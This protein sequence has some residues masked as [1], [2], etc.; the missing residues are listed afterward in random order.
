MD[1]AST[2]EYTV[3]SLGA[4]SLLMLFQLIV[5]DVVGIKSK[6][7]PGSQIPSDHDNL[8]FRSS[9][10]VT[11]IGESVGIFFLAVMYCML[12]NASPALTAYA[13]WAFVIARSFYTLF[14][15]ANLKILRSLSFGCSLLALLALI[16]I[17]FKG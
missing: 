16:V 13:A 4:L 15:Y 8:L 1:I 3:I 9:R 6:H 2:Y 5:A 12:S 7:I 17:G 14:Y 11:N 10:A